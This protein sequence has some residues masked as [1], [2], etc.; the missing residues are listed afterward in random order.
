MSQEL[1]LSFDNVRKMGGEF[2]GDAFV[3]LPSPR[4]EYGL[5]CGVAD[6]RVFENVARIRRRVA[7]TQQVGTNQAFKGGL[8]ARREE[9]GAPPR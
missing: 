2:I 6:E 8:L 1:R 7:L 4:L 3:Q 5:K 9:P